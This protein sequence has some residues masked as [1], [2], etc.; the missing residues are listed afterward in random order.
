MPLATGEGICNSKG[1]VFIMSDRALLRMEPRSILGKKVKRLRREGFLP[2]TVYG[3]NVGPFAVQVDVRAFNEI[4]R[5]SGRTTL[6]DLQIPGQ[7]PMSAFI[8]M[9]QRHPV[10]RVIL[11]ADFHVVDLMSE[12]TVAVPLHFVGQSLLVE[13]GDAMLNQVHTSLNV[14]ALP[15]ELPSYIEVDISGLDSFDKSIHVRD[16][17]FSGP[18]TIAT[19]PDELVVGLTMMRAETDEEAAE[20]A[21]AEPELVREKRDE[22][23]E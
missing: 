16:I 3:R 5:R 15:T 8:H 2:A 18:G 14:H 21:S 7:G 10:S 12:I 11:H 9:L 17:Q 22:D 19:P 6:I 20:A 4:Y 13:R 1:V 23:E